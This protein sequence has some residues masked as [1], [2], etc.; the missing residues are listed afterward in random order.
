MYQ[1]EMRVLEY[2]NKIFKNIQIQFGLYKI[3]R[4]M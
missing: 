4:E 1:I 3:N 2:D